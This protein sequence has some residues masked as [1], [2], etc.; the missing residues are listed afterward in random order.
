M[1]GLD[2]VNINMNPSNISCLLNTWILD[3][4]CQTAWLE[5]NESQSVD[6]HNLRDLIQGVIC[7]P[8]L[9]T[10]KYVSQKVRLLMI[11]CRLVD[12]EDYHIQYSLNSD[13]TVLE[14]MLEVFRHL[15]TE[16]DELAEEGR[17]QIPSIKAE[18]VFVC[19]RQNDFKTAEEIYERQWPKKERNDNGL[20]CMTVANFVG[21]IYAVVKEVIK[22]KNPNHQYLKDYT[23][24]FFVNSLAMY[25]EKI[26]RQFDLP[27]IYK[28][29]ESFI[30]CSESPFR[31]NQSNRNNSS[32]ETPLRKYSASVLKNVEVMEFRK[33][34]DQNVLPSTSGLDAARKQTLSGIQSTIKKSNTCEK[35]PHSNTPTKEPNTNV[36]KTP[37]KSVYT[38]SWVRRNGGSAVSS[39]SPMSHPRACKNANQQ[40]RH[41]VSSPVDVQ[42]PFSP[43]SSLSDNQDTNSVVSGSSMQLASRKRRK[44]NED[45]IRK[46][47]DAVCRIGVGK[48]S[49][50]R[51]VLKT[52]RSGVDLK[53][54]WRNL[55]KTGKIEELIYE[56]QNRAKK[57]KE[58]HVLP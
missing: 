24:Q 42:R 37:D 6:K 55:C 46:F 35:L 28:V 57:R 20:A 48:W 38:G 4:A 9:K 56:T 7:R 41:N 23:Y 27:Y 52:D 40:D 58:S 39:F 22:S 53:D 50:I 5:F 26:Y 12:G 29:A 31:S 16:E 15:V 47:Y 8:F 36:F 13:L 3:W 45:E 10:R 1:A 11:L 34:R 33:T 2:G 19:C 18:A 30:E 43:D 32:Q 17:S 21:K 51:N 44:W 25:L 54:K 49:E 14:D